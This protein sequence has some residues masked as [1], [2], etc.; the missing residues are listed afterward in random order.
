MA[1]RRRAIS[2]PVFYAAVLACGLI[3]L[4][5]G[6]ELAVPR[7]KRWVERW[8]LSRRIR[9]ADPRLRLATVLSMERMD[10]D[11]TSSCLIEAA[12]DPDAAVR[13][14]ACRTLATRD[15]HLGM[16][17]PILAATARDANAQVRMETAQALGRIIAWSTERAKAARAVPDAL[18][19]EMNSILIGLL[20]DPTS[21]VRTVAAGSLGEGLGRAPPEL[22]SAAD[23]ADRSVRLAV[24]RSLARRNGP[25]DPA[26]GRLLA[27]LIADPAPF[28]NRF[29]VLNLARQLGGVTC[30]QAVR[31]LAGLVPRADAVV[32]PDVIACLGLS[33]PSAQVALPVLNKLLDDPEPTTRASAVMAI[34]AIDENPNDRVLSALIDM[35]ASKELAEGQRMDALSRLQETRPKTLVKTTPALIRQLGDQ[36]AEARRVAAELLSLIVEDAPAEMPA[37]GDGK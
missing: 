4:Y 36:S 23:D 12:H 15:N 2:S 21:E 26:T 9:S 14:A 10:P 30:D 29:E 27:T 28:A 31:A 24:A 33:G 17:V 5:Y 6:V 25:G 19:S 13:V 20:K 16:T 3:G 1:R 34:L 22:V 8:T 32:L 7:A 11:L 37:E 18:I 35:V